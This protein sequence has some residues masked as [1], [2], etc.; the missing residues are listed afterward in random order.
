MNSQI[1]TILTDLKVND[2]IIPV[3]HFRYKGNSKTFVTWQIIS[4]APSLMADDEY[5]YSVVSVDVDVFSDSNYSNIVKEIKK[6]FISNG[7]VWSEDSSEM[8]EDETQIY[9]KTITFEKE[10]EL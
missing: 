7:W 6:R 2:V 9:H 1:K 4:E 3:A 10:K 8:Y 5:L